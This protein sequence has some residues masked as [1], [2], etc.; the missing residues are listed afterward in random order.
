MSQLHEVMFAD[1]DATPALLRTAFAASGDRATT[2]PA[3]GEWSLAD[4]LNH[5]RASDAIISTRVYQVLARDGAHLL[6]FDERVWG[7][8]YKAAAIDPRAQLEQFALRRAEFVAILRTL[9]PAQLARTGR[10]EER[11]PMT[12]ADLCRMLADH[13]ADHRPQIERLGD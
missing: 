11:G 13:E 9:A 8:L 10:H 1:L 7:D 12:V 3:G 4:L 5:L 2:A 6:G